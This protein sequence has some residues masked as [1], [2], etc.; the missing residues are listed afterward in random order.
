MK[1][2]LLTIRDEAK[3]GPLLA[4]LRNLDFLGVI[5]VDEATAEE[6][7]QADEEAFF[8]MAGIW[9]DRPLDQNSLRQAAWSRED[10]VTP[11]D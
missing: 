11:E 2:V 5:P 6:W 9:A 7:R 1:H 3:A 8:A 4:F 10:S